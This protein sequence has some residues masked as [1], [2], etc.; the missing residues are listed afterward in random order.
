MDG[1]HDVCC[2]GAHWVG[3]R[4]TDKRLCCQVKNN[5]GGK[6]GH[7]CFE[8]VAVPHIAANVFENIAYV[9]CRK[10]IW[11][12]R[13][14]KRKSPNPRP[15]ARQPKRKPTPLEASM[16]RE[17]NS[18]PKPWIHHVFHG[19]LPLAQSSSSLCLSRSVSI[20]CQKPR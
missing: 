8:T 17:E 9:C 3:I 19:A 20:G 18:P 14:V 10:H 4:A 12:R 15:F 2:V 5:F 13:R 16:P 6:F 1:A 7:C 11:L